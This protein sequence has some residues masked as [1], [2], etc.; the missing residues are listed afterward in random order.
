MI[1]HG[2]GWLLRWGDLVC[3]SCGGPRVAGWGL[4]AGNKAPDPKNPNDW[5]PLCY[6]CTIGE[7]TVEALARR[8]A[9]LAQRGVRKQRG[10][11]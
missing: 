7:N 6:V 9:H 5:Q 10:S 11:K 2:N 3:P 1:G 8:D 4:Y